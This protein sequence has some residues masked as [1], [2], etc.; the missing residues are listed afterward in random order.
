MAIYT[1]FI[2][3]AVCLLLAGC[4]KE[5]PAGPAGPAG[6]P[7]QDGAGNVHVEGFTAP[8]SGWDQLPNGLSYTQQIPSLTQEVIDNDAVIL[9]MEKNGIWYVLP[10][11]V[12]ALHYTYSY[13][14]GEITITLT[15]TQIPSTVDWK[16]V[17]MEDSE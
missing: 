8:S 4:T 3:A 2:V 12:N 14:P 7:G 17:Y 10:Y 6:T 9:F 1:G 16:L 13:Q 11:Q 5:G 15:G